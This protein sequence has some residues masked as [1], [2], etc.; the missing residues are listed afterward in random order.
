MAIQTIRKNTNMK[1]RK[2]CL[3]SLSEFHKYKNAKKACKTYFMEK[4]NSIIIKEIVFL[5]LLC[6]KTSKSME[7]T[8]YGETKRRYE[9]HVFPVWV[10]LSFLGNK[11][12]KATNSS[13]YWKKKKKHYQKRVFLVYFLSL[14]N[15]TCKASSLSKE[16]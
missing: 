7:T 1:I 14:G 10:F 12:L 6:R 8:L 3:F 2:M 15:K 16:N 9:K 5:F 4:E 11:T 13:L